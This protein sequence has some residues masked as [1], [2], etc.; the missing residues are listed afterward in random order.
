MDRIAVITMLAFVTGCGGSLVPMTEENLAQLEQQPQKEPPAPVAGPAPQ[1]TAPKEGRIGDKRG[2]EDLLGGGK[3]PGGSKEDALGTPSGSSAPPVSSTQADTPEQST[4][5]SWLASWLETGDG[6]L[7][8]KKARVD[9][10]WDEPVNKPATFF[11]GPLP[12]LSLSQ[13]SWYGVDTRLEGEKLDCRVQLEIH[14]PC[15]GCGPGPLHDVVLYARYD[16]KPQGDLAVSTR[17]TVILEMDV[18]DVT[19]ASFDRPLG[20]CKVLPGTWGV[21]GTIDPPVHLCGVLTYDDAPQGGVMILND[22]AEV[23]VFDDV[24]HLVDHEVLGTVQDT[25]MGSPVPVGTIDPEVHVEL[26]L[27]TE[28]L[29]VFHEK[30]QPLGG[31]VGSYGG[32]EAFMRVG[33]LTYYVHDGK[34][35]VPIFD[36]KVDV[37]PDAPCASDYELQ[38]YQDLVVDVVPECTGQGPCDLHLYYDQI[39]PT[40][41][42]W[43]EIWTFNGKKYVKSKT[44]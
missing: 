8:A 43:E 24:G 38:K 19:Q 16:L 26:D 37:Y 21:A 13:L 7:L 17:V 35:L 6:S 27:G 14:S 32:C 39:S 3:P 2:K 4:C 15:D 31:H 9:V 5:K 40:D 10:L 44:L 42:I 22:V 33:T 41:K 28:V 30:I 20:E 36:K 34:K 29:S 12:D 23:L 1:P 11:P 18:D 25:E